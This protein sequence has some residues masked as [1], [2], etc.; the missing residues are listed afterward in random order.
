MELKMALARVFGVEPKYAAK[1]GLLLAE[2]S[3]MTE[4]SLGCIDQFADDGRR[5]GVVPSRTG[6]RRSCR[7]IDVNV[8]IA[9]DG[10]MR[11]NEIPC[12]GEAGVLRVCERRNGNRIGFPEVRHFVNLGAGKGD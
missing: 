7:H 11:D 5:T 3:E 2:R 1:V 6:A 4:L 9:R 8:A 12:S 10:R